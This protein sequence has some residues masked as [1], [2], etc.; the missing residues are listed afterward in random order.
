[1][2]DLDFLRW[3]YTAVTRAKKELYL[4]NFAPQLFAKT[5]QEDYY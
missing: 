4:V 2:I 1:M 3:L 5:A